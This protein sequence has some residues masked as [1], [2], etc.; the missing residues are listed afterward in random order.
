MR[1]MGQLTSDERGALAVWQ[2]K[3]RDST[4]SVDEHEI[5]STKIQEILHTG[6][7]GHMYEALSA[8][9]AKLDEIKEGKSAKGIGAVKKELEEFKGAVEDQAAGLQV[10]LETLFN[11]TDAVKE[12]VDRAVETAAQATAQAPDQRILAC[13]TAISELKALVEAQGLTIE[14]LQASVALQSDSTVLSQL[15]RDEVDSQA[16]VA[17]VKAIREVIGEGAEGE[18]IEPPDSSDT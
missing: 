6:P 9:D 13:G 8:F 4:M 14:R 16:R 17:A 3:L 2:G 7:F 11:V 5:A 10:Q 12:E 1:G 15:I 18:D